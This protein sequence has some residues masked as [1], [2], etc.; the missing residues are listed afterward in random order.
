MYLVYFSY[1]NTNN[2]YTG[3]LVANNNPSSCNPVQ[4]AQSSSSLGSQ[5]VGGS[6]KIRLICSSCNQEFATTTELN[7]H[8]ERH[9]SEIDQVLLQHTSSIPSSMPVTLS[10][11]NAAATTRQRSIALS[12]VYCGMQFRDNVSLLN[13]QKR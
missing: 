4:T 13:H 9:N 6:S 3:M 8:M 5:L 11:T 10:L 7:E 12:C 1:Q 2:N